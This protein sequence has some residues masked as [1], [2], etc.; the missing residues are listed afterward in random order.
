[1]TTCIG[2]KAILRKHANGYVLRSYTENYIV[3]I[4]RYTSF[5]RR[6]VGNVVEM[7]DDS[8]YQFEAPL[9]DNIKC[10]WIAQLKKR[11][12]KICNAF[13]NGEMMRDRCPKACRW[14]VDFVPYTTEPSYLSSGNPSSSIVP[15]TTPSIHPSDE[16]SEQ[17]SIKPTSAP[18]VPPTAFHQH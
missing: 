2:T 17:P 4:L 15:L 11:Q 5:A 14:C 6:L 13:R 12:N 3:K 18:T 9:K 1:M 10:S 8:A 7:T 16:P